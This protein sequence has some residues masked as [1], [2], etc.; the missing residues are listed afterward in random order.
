M[1]IQKYHSD[2]P[3]EKFLSTRLRIRQGHQLISKS[4][5]QLFFFSEI[6][7]VIKRGKGLDPPLPQRYEPALSWFHNALMHYAHIQV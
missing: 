4:D 3:L 2:Q 7:L 5:A 1:E 6:L